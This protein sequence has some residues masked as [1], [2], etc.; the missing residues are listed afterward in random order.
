MA[1][2][3]ALDAAGQDGSELQY[4]LWVVEVRIPRV[5]VFR[6]TLVYS[7]PLAN[8]LP[9]T[10]GLS[11]PFTRQCTP[12]WTTGPSTHA[13]ISASSAAPPPL[14]LH[15]LTPSKRQLASMASPL[16]PSRA[17]PTHSDIIR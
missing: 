7:P 15:A 12:C 3:E 17:S 11:S 16:L 14:P 4:Y 13:S 1:P 8:H 5:I 2:T 10:S 9:P 6:S